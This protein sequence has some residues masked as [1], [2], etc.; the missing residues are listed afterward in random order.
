MRDPNRLD[1]FY[2]ELKA[3]HK[4]WFPDLRFGQLYSNFFGWLMQEKGVDLFFP[5]EERMLKYLKE[6]VGYNVNK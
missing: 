6:Y 3:I 4:E 5:E 1:K 2:D